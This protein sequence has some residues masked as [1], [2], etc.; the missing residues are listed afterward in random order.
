MTY[1]TIFTL[2]IEIYLIFTNVSYVFFKLR[3]FLPP[4]LKYSYRAKIYRRIAEF[5]RTGAILLVTMYTAIEFFW[6]SSNKIKSKEICRSI[7]RVPAMYFYFLLNCRVLFA[8]ARFVM[9][10]YSLSW[11]YKKETAGVFAMLLIMFV[12]ITWYQ[13]TLYCEFYEVEEICLIKTN[14]L[15]IEIFVPIW[16][17]YE[18]A[19]FALY[20]TPLKETDGLLRVNLDGCANLLTTK[21]Q[22]LDDIMNDENRSK[23]ESLRLDRIRSTCAISNSTLE[24][25]QKFHKSVRRHFWAGVI[26]MFA[27]TVQYLQFLIFNGTDST[28]KFLG[29]PDSTRMWYWQS[30]VGVL[31]CRSLGIILYI[32]MMLSENNSQRAFIPYFVWK[33]ES[34][35]T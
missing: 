16:V 29:I 8:Y 21:N 7:S 26:I 5:S 10:K 4:R 2:I 20:Y 30:G 23:N 25:I 28:S 27:G 14:T 9:F 17:I 18:A 15:W 19:S 6:A 1:I 24:M 22:Q 33:R 34:W 11:P 13:E 3:Y 35:D 12:C 32:S 31:V